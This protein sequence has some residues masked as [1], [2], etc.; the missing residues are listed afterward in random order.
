MNHLL[1]MQFRRHHYLKLAMF[2]YYLPRLLHR[3]RQMV[4][5][6]SFQTLF[7]S[8][9]CYLV[10]DLWKAYFPIRQHLEW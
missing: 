7:R 10:M 2:R 6:R 5:C 1:L 8:H 3:R 9:H 4:C